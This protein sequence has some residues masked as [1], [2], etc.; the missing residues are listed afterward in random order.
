M[1]SAPV[2]SPRARDTAC[3]ALTDRSVLSAAANRIRTF[4]DSSRTQLTPTGLASLASSLEPREVVAFFRNSH[5][6]VLYKRPSSAAES[7][8]TPDEPALYSL[9][10]DESFRSEPEVVWE[11]LF[12]SVSQSTGFV[13]SE[14]DQAS[15]AGGDVA[16]MTAE[17]V[18]RRA[19]QAENV[20][21]GDEDE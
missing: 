11:P 7:S 3:C 17:E 1:V 9:V 15:T 18:A 19:D 2:L 13:N 12:A 21:R 8:T 5:L 16:G 20:R 14:F 4:L 10:T 6:S